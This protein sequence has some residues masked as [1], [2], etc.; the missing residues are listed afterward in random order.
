MG[1]VD[2]ALLSSRFTASRA[3]WDPSTLTELVACIAEPSSVG[4]SA[5]AGLL[6]PTNRA[7]PGGVQVTFGDGVGANMT[8]APIAPGLYADVSVESVRRLA[9]DEEVEVAGPGTLSF[10]G[11]RDVALAQDQRARLRVTGG[12]P[13]VIDV[14]RALLASTSTPTMEAK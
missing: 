13:N 6:A 12:G 4:L 8:R 1:L 5:V 2:V 9:T 10:D 3:V 7:E 11:E 14:D